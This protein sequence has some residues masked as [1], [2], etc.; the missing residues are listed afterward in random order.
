MCVCFVCL[1]FSDGVYEQLLRARSNPRN[2]RYLNTILSVLLRDISGVPQL[3]SVDELLWVTLAIARGSGICCDEGDGIAHDAMARI[4]KR[5]EASRNDFAGSPYV[6]A[7]SLALIGRFKESAE[8]LWA[9]K[10]PCVQ[11]DAAHIAL[12]IALRI[13]RP[14]QLSYADETDEESGSYGSD[15]EEENGSGGD[16]ECEDEAAAAGVFSTSRRTRRGGGMGGLAAALSR[17]IEA[18]P[19]RVGLNKKGATPYL[20]VSVMLPGGTTLIRQFLDESSLASS[21]DGLSKRL[22]ESGKSPERYCVVAEA[23]AAEGSIKKAMYLFNS[24]GEYGRAARL[25]Y[26][27][28]GSVVPLP[29]G[30]PERRELLK[31]AE[32]L[33][34][35]REEDTTLRTLRAMSEFFDLFHDG[36]WVDAVTRPD[37]CGL[38][39][40]TDC[41]V[42]AVEKCARRFLNVFRTPKEVAQ[43]VPGVLVAMMVC[44]KHCCAGAS[45]TDKIIRIHPYERATALITF[46][47]LVSERLPPE[48]SAALLR[49]KEQIERN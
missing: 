26:T 40:S 30:E 14:G 36:K 48:T 35:H 24:V 29:K 23:L 1:F 5:L 12:A 41:S 16:G 18:Y 15:G 46:A 49:V 2:D 6:Y 37:F 42:E 7:A 32:A 43:N 11:I 47:A 31:F 27:L 9:S 39:P 44:I 20:N 21:A 13:P 45:Y 22:K 17:I 3:G 28:L 34:R 8:Y 25:L 4:C 19:A 33:E 10:D 38:L